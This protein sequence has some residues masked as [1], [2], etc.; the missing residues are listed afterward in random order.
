MK[1]AIVTAGTLPVPA[2]RG[3]AVENLV[4]S[5]ARVNEQYRKL[6]LTVIGV[7]DQEAEK[8]ARKYSHTR[9][10]FLKSSKF[11]DFLDRM[12]YFFAS[13]LLKRGGSASFRYIFRRFSMLRQS[14]QILA[15]GN[16]DKVV[17]ENS[18]TL[19]RALK[20]KNNYKK[21]AGNYYYHIHNSVSGSYGCKKIIP[22]CKTLAVSRYINQSLP[23]FMRSLPENHLRVVYN[24]IDTDRFGQPLSEKEWLSIRHQYELKQDDIVLLFVGRLTREKGVKELLTAFQ[25]IND[26]NVKLLI[27]GSRFFDSD[28]HS[29]FEIE[30]KKLS[31]Q[32]ADKVKI[33]GFIPYEEIPQ[34]YAIADIAVLPSI[35]EEPAGL[36]M[37]EAEAS[38]LPVIT[39][40]AGGIP[41]YVGENAII[42]RRDGELVNNIC[43]SINLLIQ[44]TKLRRKLSHLSIRVSA[45]YTNKKYYWNFIDQISN[46]SVDG[47]L[48][49]QTE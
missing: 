24:G 32:M 25:Q 5:L 38:G 29:S 48:L 2:V 19:F 26:P 18:A 16:F 34:I 28:I 46:K 6:E 31:E 14:A 30:L 11:I 10:I 36:T 13:K 47:S 49:R 44:N 21:Y 17:L 4:E 45:A 20:R 1:V 42:L 3:G 39:T 9:F 35:W 27:V 8:Q 43:R 41:E 7:Y 37:V 40:D 33:T 15:D 22:G 23:D 12:A